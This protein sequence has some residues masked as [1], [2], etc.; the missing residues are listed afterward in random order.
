MG[1]NSKKQAEAELWIL[2][3]MGI[4]PRSFSMAVTWSLWLFQAKIRYYLDSWEPRK[5]YR[6]S[7]WDGFTRMFRILKIAWKCEL[8]WPFGGVGGEVGINLK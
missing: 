6:K 3:G 4:C 7:P 1:V 5:D 8:F 2:L